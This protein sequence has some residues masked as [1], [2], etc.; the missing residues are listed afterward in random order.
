[1]NGR[2]SGVPRQRLVICVSYLR[3][4]YS[5]TERM[6]HSDYLSNPDRENPYRKNLDHE[7]TLIRV[8]TGHP[9]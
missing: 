8:L 5:E 2:R 4:I 1:M 6:Q 3:M 7:Q 9:T